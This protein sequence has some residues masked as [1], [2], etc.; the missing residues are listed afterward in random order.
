MACGTA[1][2]LR[3]GAPPVHSK[4]RQHAQH[5]GAEDLDN[6][7]LGIRCTGVSQMLLRQTQVQYAAA[8]LTS[9]H[10]QAT[11]KQPVWDMPQHMPTH[12]TDSAHCMQGRIPVR[13]NGAHNMPEIKEST[14]SYS[15]L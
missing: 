4:A 1:F 13:E 12:K 14:L 3:L 15:K 7:H 5:G 9:A 2:S 6:L 10:K 8:Y 11:V